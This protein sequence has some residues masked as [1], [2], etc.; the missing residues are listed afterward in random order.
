MNAILPISANGLNIQ[1]DKKYL[2]AVSGGVDSM[3]MAALFLQRGVNFAVAHC[4]FSLRIPDADLDATLV[5]TWCHDHQIPFFTNTFDT[6][7][8]ATNESLSIQEAARILRYRYFS[9]LIQEHGYDFIATAHHCDDAIETALFH[10]LRGTGIRGL[11]GIPSQNGTIVRPMLHFSRAAIEAYASD[12]QVPFRTDASNKE[13]KYTRN[14]IRNEILPFI[15]KRFPNV[16]EQ[17]AAN[18]KRMQET[19]ILFNEAID[20]KK[21]KL[22]EQRG[23][24]FYIPL[25]KLRNVK[26]LFTI[27]YELISPFGFHAEQVDA[28]IQ[29]M[30]GHS[31]SW[32]QSQTHK[33]IRDREFLIITQVQTTA[34]ERIVIEATDQQI[35][36][37][38]FEL[39]LKASAKSGL[40]QNNDGR[41]ES[42]D[43]ALLQ[44]PLILRKWRAGDYLYPIG[45]NKKKKVARLLIDAKISLADKERIWVL[46]SDQ[47]I[48]WVVGIK[49][50][51]RFR[52]TEQTKNV[53][54]LQ[55][56]KT[57]E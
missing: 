25:R 31:G 51:H 49:L 40:P 15:E 7:A 28:V 11:A 5:A 26:P 21:K 8:F 18:L 50:D 45:M 53:L 12:K 57:N 1:V 13:N 27:T 20:Q 29:L 10:Y 23:P 22:I 56:L 16:R 55:C 9:D 4:H 44:Y 48:I 32:I 6:K 2:L 38:D 17:L 30:D 35:R 42:I 37:A 3:V 41:T 33:L 54:T 39:K 46:E 14:Q 34:S 43:A 24:D 47:R 36:C 19:T 52:I